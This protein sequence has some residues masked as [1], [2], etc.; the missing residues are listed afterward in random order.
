MNVGV[1]C[2]TECAAF[3]VEDDE[4]DCAS[5]INAGIATGIELADM[6]EVASR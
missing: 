3:D 5:T 2:V 4:Q 1:H 6:L